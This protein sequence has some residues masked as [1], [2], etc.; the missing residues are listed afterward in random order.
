MAFSKHYLYNPTD[1]IIG[2][3]AHAFSHP[4]RI[5]IIKQL[6]TL[7]PSAVQLIARD[8]TIHKESM[9]GHL[10]IL[11]HYELVEGQEKYPYTFYSVQDDNLKKA[12]QYLS[13]FL[14]MIRSV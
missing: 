5:L 11:R 4:A 8:H 12:S 9:S 10:K 2:G 6:L 3:Y 7:G 1:Q 13:E 14:E